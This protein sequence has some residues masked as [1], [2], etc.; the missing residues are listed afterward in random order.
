VSIGSRR[1]GFSVI[2][3][4]R[5]IRVYELRI[6][7]HKRMTDLNEEHDLPRIKLLEMYLCVSFL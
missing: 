2:A 7:A 3:Y 6:F 5:K 1:L 4:P